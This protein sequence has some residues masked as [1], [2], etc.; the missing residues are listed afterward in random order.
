M[1]TCGYCG[2]EAEICGHCH[3]CVDHCGCGFQP[4]EAAFDEDELGLDPE[5][6]NDPGDPSR[7][8]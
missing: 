1:T 3:N 8:A 5:S 7:H 2:I 4:T 6:D